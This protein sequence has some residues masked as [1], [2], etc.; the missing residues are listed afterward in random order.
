MLELPLPRSFIDNGTFKQVFS[1]P[2][3]KD[4][5]IHIG[6]GFH[7]DPNCKVYAIDLETGKKLWERE[8]TSQ[9]ESGP[10]ARS[11]KV[12]IGAGNDGFLCLNAVKGDI[13]WQFPPKDY[14]GRLLRFGAGAAVEG[15]NSRARQSVSKSFLIACVAKLRASTL[16]M[17]RAT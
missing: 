4:G 5:R 12:F 13:V 6:E 7:E 8:T 3:V 16:P 11:G 1:A 17:A 14:K 9:T 15:A 10:I 2:T